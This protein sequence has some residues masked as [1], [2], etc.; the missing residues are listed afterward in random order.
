MDRITQAALDA[1]LLANRVIDVEDLSDK[2]SPE[3]DTRTGLGNGTDYFYY[4]MAGFKRWGVQ[5]E[6][7][8]PTDGTI[9][10]TVEGSLN[11]DGT[12]AS[13]CTYDDYTSKFGAASFPVTATGTLSLIDDKG[14]MGL[15]KYVRVK[16]VITGSTSGNIG[17]TAHKRSVAL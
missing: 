8:R 6:I 4:D 7:T 2:I 14:C 1:A 12:A 10:F 15:C 16:Y 17:I 9:T 3:V 11:D 5:L 13:S